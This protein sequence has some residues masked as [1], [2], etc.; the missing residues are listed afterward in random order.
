MSA[1][2][3]WLSREEDSFPVPSNTPVLHFVRLSALTDT[4]VHL[5]SLV[6][7]TGWSLAPKPPLFDIK[8][9]AR[10]EYFFH[11][12]RNTSRIGFFHAEGQDSLFARMEEIVRQSSLQTRFR[13]SYADD[14]WNFWLAVYMNG[15]ELRFDGDMEGAAAL[16]LLLGELMRSHMTVPL[17]PLPDSLAERHFGSNDNNR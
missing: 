13:T 10:G 8:L 5:D 17:R 7:S 14:G 11:G 15:S 12:R 6:F 9:T 4:T 1:D 2:S 16:H 3:L